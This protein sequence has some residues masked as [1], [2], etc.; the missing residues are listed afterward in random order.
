MRSIRL[1][2][3]LCLLVASAARA[4]FPGRYIGVGAAD[5]MRLALSAARGDRL[6]GE[7][8]LSDGVA[9]RFQ[10]EQVG[11]VVEGALAL[12]GGPLF[13]QII[14][15]GPGVA[16]RLTP[17]DREGRMLLDQAVGYAFVPEGTPIPDLPQRFIPEPSR[18]I[19]AIDAEAFVA[20]Y[21]FWS[22]LGAALGYEAVAER[23]R[24]VIRLFPMVQTDLLRKLCQSPERTPGIAEA[25][26]GQGVT[27][28]DVL[29]ALPEGGGARARFG[30]AVEAERALLQTALDCANR[31]TSVPPR[32]AEA[33]R[34]TARRAASMDTVATVLR[35][36]R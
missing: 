5:G 10:A 2:A 16:A 27:C 29:A 4:D 3:I 6:D 28:R 18:A 30:A 19:R 23:Y 25:L 35:R 36:Y 21:P 11:R 24:T 31:L 12:D 32:C 17:V 14:E 9:R 33:G 7:I 34:E 26:R 22:P 8:T 15:D 13:L 20:S 1:L